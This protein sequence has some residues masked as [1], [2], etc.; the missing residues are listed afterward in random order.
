MTIIAFKRLN[1]I[2]QNNSTL[3]NTC[4]SI[5]ERHHKIHFYHS[6][7]VPRFSNYCSDFS[8]WKFAKKRTNWTQFI[9]ILHITH[10]FK[11]LI[12]RLINN[13]LRKKH[14]GM[15]EWKGRISTIKT[16]TTKS[17]WKMHHHFE[18]LLSVYFCQLSQRTQL[19]FDKS[20]R[21]NYFFKSHNQKFSSTN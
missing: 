1:L 13:F 12:A 3:V 10:F 20:S 5:S 11:V 7:D 19:K 9:L 4:S 16:K 17:A 8:V 18:R 15:F 6:R 2:H 14:K 21:F